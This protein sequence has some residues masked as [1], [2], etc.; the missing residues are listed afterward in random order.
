MAIQ[1]ADG[2]LD[3]A[4]NKEAAAIAAMVSYSHSRIGHRHD[5]TMPG[6]SHILLGERVMKQNRP[7]VL[8]VDLKACRDYKGGE[9]AAAAVACPALCVLAEADRMVPAKMGLQLAGQI[10]DCRHVVVPGA[11]HFVMSEF[12]VETNAALRPFFLGSD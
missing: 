3:M 12:S 11:G 7:G 6:Q 10:P 4:E 8:L 5:H 2:L 1:V 9:D